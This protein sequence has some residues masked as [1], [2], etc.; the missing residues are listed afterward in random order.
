MRI[1]LELVKQEQA[2]A[3]LAMGEFS[4][5][6]QRAEEELK[7]PQARVDGLSAAQATTSRKLDRLE[8]MVE[9]FDNLEQTDQP[10]P[11]PDPS[12]EL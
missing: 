1:T 2:R 9:L 8:A 6:L 7:A 5:L 11:S 10:E 12:S 3:L 4:M